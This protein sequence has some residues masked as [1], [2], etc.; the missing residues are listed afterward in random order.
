MRTILALCAVSLALPVFAQTPSK[1]VSVIGT[2][3][4]ADAA[5][6]VFTVKTDKSG[7]TTVKFDDKTSFLRIPVGET[8]IKKATPAKSTDVGP[9]DRILARVH[10]EDPTGVPALTF[11]ITKQAEIAQR[12]SKTL[13][14]WKT[15]GVAGS[16]KSVDPAA[17][18]IVISVRGAF[19]PPKEVT[20]DASAPAVSFER[21]RPDAAKYEPDTMASIQPGD[22]LRVLGTKNA[23]QTQIKAEAIMSGSFRTVPVQ[24]KSID[25]ASGQI[26][27]TDLAS[28]KPI[29]I[30]VRADTAMK[31][32]DDAT[33][34][35]MARRLNP[36]AGGGRG[37]GQGG[38]APDGA[39]AGGGGRGFGGGGGRGAGGGGRSMDPTALLESQP[40]I[41]LSDLKAG[42][43]VVVTG[44]SGSDMSK[45]TATSLVAGVDPIL[46]AAP[47]NGPDPLGGSWNLGDGGPPQ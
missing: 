20:L 36:A 19:G 39:A 31:K 16:V 28:K 23:D 41:Q 22:Q 1:Y 7:D 43:P 25:A 29:T 45:L 24:I 47:A 18:S 4:A 34:A 12:N 21:Y 5:G 40:T 30:I 11:Y 42:E 37:R 6:H 26:A 3:T 15:Q 44:S 35:M 46:R 17:K 14:E 13:E 9:G 33:A 32:L 38:G 8:D 2:V 10:T 27:A